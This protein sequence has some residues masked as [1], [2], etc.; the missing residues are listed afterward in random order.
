[1]NSSSS[2]NLNNFKFI[3]I[4]KNYFLKHFN[5]LTNLSINMPKKKPGKGDKSKKSLKNIIEDDLISK[6]KENLQESYFAY[7]KQN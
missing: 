6:L 7:Q 5:N 3:S 4:F 1:M 2:V